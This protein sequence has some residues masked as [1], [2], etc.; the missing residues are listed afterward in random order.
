MNITISDEAIV[1]IKKLQQ[2]FGSID[3]ALRFGL[4][5][6]GCS[7]Y[8]YVLEFEDTPGESDVVLKTR[9]IIIYVDS[10]YENKLKDSVIDWQETPF[11]SGFQ[12]HN[13]QAKQSCGCG[14]SI[15][16]NEE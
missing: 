13:P 3:S 6:A 4:A 7:G 12:I 15:N 8:K 16:F 11:L 5:K 1:N 10:A 2:D 9:G 14:E